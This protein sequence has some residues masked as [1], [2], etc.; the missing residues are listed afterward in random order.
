V[1]NDLEGS[2]SNRCAIAIMAKAPS[3]GRVKTRLSPLLSP[4]EAKDLGCCFLRDM[5]TNLARAAREVPIDPYIAFAPAGD[6]AAFEPI[7]APGTA[8]VLADG[9]RP[10]PPGVEGF[11]A[12]LLQAAAALFDA[13]YGAVALLNS[14]SPTLPTS[15]LVKAAQHLLLP[16][17]R[18]VLGPSFDGGYY[19][20]GMRRPHAELF[21]AI[22]WSTERVATQTR[23]RALGR[24]LNVVDLEA[25]YDVD[26]AR[27]LLRLVRDLASNQAPDHLMAYS[28][29]ATR[30][31]V[32]HHAL[33]DRL[34]ACG[35]TSTAVQTGTADA[36]RNWSASG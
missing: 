5:M 13:E 27:S 14:D 7:I 24:G 2:R 9:S 1:M 30:T 15:L 36:A 10:A 26:D 11:G 28:A 25:W 34:A 29:P 18:L 3:A 22:D 19:L 17:D 32:A 20:V 31:F 33:A 16:H 21:C 4:L 23:E 8:L 12:C 35:V 6:E